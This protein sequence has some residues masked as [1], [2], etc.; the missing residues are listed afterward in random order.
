M[1]A[2]T[3]GEFKARFSELLS[4]VRGREEIEILFGKAKKPV[5][6]LVPLKGTNRRLGVLDGKARFSEKDG[7]KITEEEFLGLS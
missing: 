7:G 3:V 6:M 2:F 1:K 4:I 5:A